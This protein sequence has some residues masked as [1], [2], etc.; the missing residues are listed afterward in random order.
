MGLE[1]KAEII[2]SYIRKSERII[3]RKGH[4]LAQNYD[5]TIEQYHLLVYL[6]MQDNPPTIGEIA[7]KYCNAQNTM[8]EK[9]SRLE[10]KQLV[11]RK[12]DPLDRRITRVVVSLKGEKLICMIKKERRNKSVLQA[13][14]S[15]DE[16]NIENLIIN[17]EILYNNLSKEE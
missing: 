3:H 1:E 15:M 9:I 2:A 5:L 14:N 6:N 11:E 8:S 7:D 17:L 16:R 13:L 10:E 4:E 12:S